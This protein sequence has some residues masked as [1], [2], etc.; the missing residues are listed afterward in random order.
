[1]VFQEIPRPDVTIQ[2]KLLLTKASANRRYIMSLDN[3]ALLLPYMIEAALPTDIAEENIHGGWDS[4]VSQIRGHFLGHWLSAASMFYAATGDMEVK[5]KADAV[6]SALAQCQ[7]A[8]GGEWAASIPEKYLHR[9]AQG[10]QVW[11]PQYTIHKTFMGLL[12]MYRYTRNGQALDIA[13]KWSPWFLSW[14]S[15]FSQEEMDNILDFET[16]GMLEIWVDLYDITGKKDYLTL[17]EKYYRGR[18]FDPLLS[19]ED[20]LTNMHANTTIPEVLGAAR[21]YEVLGDTKYLNIV[22]NYWRLAVTE[23]GQYCTGGQTC[24]EIWTPKQELSAR[25]GDKNQEHCTVYNMM[26][27]ADFLFRQTGEKIY[28]DYQEQNLYNGIFAQGY[29]QGSFTH[30]NHSEYPETGL[31]TYFLPLRAG[32]RKAWSSEK[33][34]FFCCHG[35]LTQ[36][37]ASLNR[38]IYYASDEG[39]AVCQYFDSSAICNIK[40]VPV[41]LEQKID[42]LSGNTQE[43]NKT[44]AAHPQNPNILKTILSIRCNSRIEF[45]LKIR[46][47]WWTKNTPLVHINGKQIQSNI[48]DGYIALSRIWENDTVSVE[49]SR[50]ISLWPLPDRPDTAA[51]LYGPVVLAGLCDA[52]IELRGNAARLESIIVPDNEREWGIWT[53]T[54]KTTGQNKNIRLIPLYAVGYEPYTVYFPVKCQ[55]Q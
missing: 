52:E 37:N 10:R 40:N 31:L 26:R 48:A 28:A 12:D 19:G 35:T 51:F 32:G 46:L 43:V 8:N 45:E 27:L 55:A 1:M 11:A 44:C 23:R 7:K 3:D 9:I 36:A 38:G 2:D 15:A 33:K 39:I 29:W 25:L 13:D 17:I 21:A 16:G 20:V 42:T 47:P 5:A 24:G 30:G 4:P 54:F 18:L 49:F 34:H 50:G 53:K 6:V 14:T 41:H 22:K